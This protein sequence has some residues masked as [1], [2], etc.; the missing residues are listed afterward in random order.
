MSQAKKIGAGHYEYL[1]V[2][3]S[4]VNSTP[5][6]WKVLFPGGLISE[7]FKTLKEAKATIENVV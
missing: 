4:K 3:I 5:A 6:T 1:G 7:H 2:P